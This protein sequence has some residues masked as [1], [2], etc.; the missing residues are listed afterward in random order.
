MSYGRVGAENVYSI[1][2]AGSK[3][4]L[5]DLSTPAGW[6]MLWWGLAVVIILVMFWMM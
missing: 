4:G 2:D 6:T 3:S 5:F 1:G